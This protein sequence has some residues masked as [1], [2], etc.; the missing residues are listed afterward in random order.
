MPSRNAHQERSQPDLELKMQL[1][2]QSVSMGRALR[3]RFIIKTRQP[4][5]EFT[6][7]VR[8]KAKLALLEQMESL[9][10]EE[11]NVK[12]IRF[13][14]QEDVV[15]SIGAKANFKKLG[16]IIRSENERCCSR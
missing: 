15:V 3:S 6:V 7:I 2:R 14:T 5:H 11:L 1:I 10:R 9:I 4:L 16:K 8:D 13:S 12:S